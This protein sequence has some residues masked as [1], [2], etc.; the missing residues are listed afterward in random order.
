MLALLSKELKSVFCSVAVLFFSVAFLVISGLFLWFFSGR[1]NIL[2]GGYADM[3]PFFTI[4]PIILIILIPALTMRMFAEEK[5][6]GMFVMLKSFPVRMGSVW[7]AK[8]TAC[9]ILILV[10]LT[11]TLIYVVSVYQLA[12]PVGNVDINGI[13][14]SYLSLSV[15]LAV[16]LTIGLFASAITSNQIVAFILGTVLCAFSFYGFDL[17]AGL[18]SS[19]K[20]QSFI[21]T[22]GLADHYTMTQ[23]GVL[24]LRSI[25]IICIY[26]F[27]FYKLALASIKN[28]SSRM[29]C[30]DIIYMSILV[31]LAVFVNARVDLTSDKKY[32]LGNYTKEL[33]AKIAQ[34]DANVNINV[35]LEG[36]FN[37]GFLRLKD[38]AKELLDDIN[39]E[40]DDKVNYSF[41]NPYQIYNSP[42]QTYKFMQQQGMPGISLNEVDREGKLSRKI[43]YPYAQVINDTD[44][45]V[46]SLL[47]NVAGYTAEENLNASVENL[48]YEFADALQI[49][50][51]EQPQSVAFIEGHGEI[52][53]PNVYDA[54]ELLSKYYSVH[55]GQI[56]DQVGI[57]D[58]FRVVIIAGPT[59]K[60]TE[61]EKYVLDQY[62]MSGGRVLWLVDGAYTPL[63]EI[64][65]KGQAASMKLDV[66]LDDMLFTYGVRINADLVQDKQSASI[67][68]V[69]DGDINNTIKLPCY[70][71]PL[72]IPSHD[73]IITRNIR[74]VKAAFGSSLDFVNSGA[75]IKKTVL[76]TTSGYTHL[77]DV[78]QTVSLDIADAQ[79]QSGYF[80]QSY[81]TMAVLLEGTF[82][83]VYQNRLVPDVYRPVDYM[84]TEKGKP[85][86]MIVVS[87]SQIISNE[88]EGKG[89]D[90]SIIPMGYDRVSS[91]Q[92]GNRDFIVNA[93]NWLAGNEELMALRS[94]ER[95][96][97]LL[98]KTK[99]Y[100][101]RNKYA[102]L[103]IGLPVLF[104]L[105]IAG[106]V[107]FYRKRKYER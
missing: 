64:Y 10:T 36:D 56:G 19:G 94:K 13:I 66:N 55:R 69:P 51:Q 74:D 17:L 78:P 14:I 18:F 9:F 21:S 24:R 60:Y 68:L 65:E 92:F 27:L 58:D 12:N 63:Q 97:Y 28:K 23:R 102:A 26:L 83:S 46:I 62:I 86:K 40:S 42:E 15:L 95:R 4:A 91:Q 37:M 101:E 22:T 38:A 72:L 7:F 44:T 85:T 54:E 2:D 30:V 41:Y 96:L 59:G 77:V 3:K 81:V 53:R 100:E 98:D 76:L 11:A 48:E 45:L 6:S 32:T 70:Y 52:P 103:N 107:S 104:M 29:V 106:G 93:V 90:T 84:T 39:N 1:Y 47:K 88:L 82:S 67:M 87:S 31:V 57:L 8:F 75:D 89:T 5:R 35:Y 71:M 33:L 43:I 49:L 34:E 79:S 61:Q 105:L 20:M 25:F 50:R 80:D 16:F 73:H 99:V